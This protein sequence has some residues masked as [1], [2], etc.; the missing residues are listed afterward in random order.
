M[1]VCRLIRV[2]DPYLL[3]TLTS[4][5]LDSQFVKILTILGNETRSLSFRKL[6]YPFLHRGQYLK[7]RLQIG[8][9]VVIVSLHINLAI[10]LVSVDTA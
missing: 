9:A 3:P 7:L 8:L 1:A 5:L 6:E 4:S 2:I 10:V